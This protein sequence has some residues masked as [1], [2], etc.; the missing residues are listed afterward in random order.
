MRRWPVPDQTPYIGRAMKRVEDPRL[1]KGIG[2]YVDD[3]RLPGLLHACILRSPYAH[4]RIQRIDTTAAKAIPG[5]VG[6]F[7]GPEVNDSCGLVP[8]AAAIP[9]LKAPKHTVLAS[10]RVYFV[11]HAVAVAVAS[12]PYIARDAI[13]AIDVDYDPLP[14]VVNPE[15]AV[16]EGTPLTHPDLGTNV[17]FT[18]SVAGGSNIDD[19][20]KRAD[21]VIKHRLYHQRLTPM[22]IEPRGAVASYHAGEGTLT[23]W[24]STQIPHLLRTL[25]PG[26]IGV[27]ENKLR[28]VAPEVGGG[29][30]AKLN[31]YA[32][33]ALV[34]HLAMRLNAPVKWIESRRENAASTIHGRDQIGEYEIAV[35]NDGTIL[36]IKSRTIADL[37]AY[38]QL[39]TP[40]VPTLTGLV[41]TGCYRIPA[42]KIDI[43]GVY[44]NKMSTDAYRGAGR[45]EATYLIE[46][47]MDV[48]AREMGVDRLEL[49]LKHFPAPTE[50]PFATSCGLTYDSGNYQGALTKAKQLAGWDQLLKERAAARAAGRLFGV[51][52]ST[53][54]EIC[55]MGPSAAM[56]AGGWEWGCV[57]MEISGKVTVI[58]GVSPHGQG[59]ETSFAQIAADRL[60]VPI[61]DVVV[62]H[63][64][65]NVAH[66]G[67]D[68]YGS[69]G[70]AVGGTAIVMCI[71]KIVAKAKAL[72]AHLLET[73][74][75]HVEFANGTFSSP[76]VTNREIPWAELAG[77]AYIA[78]SLPAGFEPGL[79]ASSFFEPSNFTFPFG[80][81]IC[82]VDV[83]RDTGHVAIKKYIAVDD[84]G[85]QINPLLVEG[86]VQ[87]GIA[88]SIGQVLFEQT[89]YDENGQLLTGEFMDYAMP[90]ASDIPEYVLGHTVT[91][92]PVNP[93]GV[94][95]VGEAGTIGS[96]PAIANAVLDALEPLGIT[97]LDLPMTPERVW[98]AIKTRTAATV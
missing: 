91:P 41:L 45:P 95:G 79:E 48:I 40:M 27:A 31:V 69:R 88:H 42:V 68:T 43:V 12:D 72:A 28:I 30:G 90:R 76:G 1:I 34:S 6:V 98:Q 61:E 33:E 93:L 2:T 18:H 77:A 55:A 60:G 39:L 51:G 17:A 65:T 53:Y 75:D 70:T 29:F 97:H 9:D 5:V 54:V 16:K 71:D 63:G 50:F 20:F 56:P 35:K 81:H 22:P 13:D 44:T 4:A 58:T 86:Q 37:G 67:R 8:C 74:A 84:C 21:R 24:S 80:T 94:K 14:V 49:R 92:S 36:G 85:P 57:R 25:L 47:L 59:Q 10:D 62:L 46:R 78:K 83:D 87:G 52:V 82:A 26:M 64:D 32:E 38:N 96:T 3:L 89:V 7:T 15:E 11:G 73:T 66:Y 19:A 23:L